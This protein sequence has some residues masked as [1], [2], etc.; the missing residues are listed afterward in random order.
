[1]VK[2]NL[3]FISIT[4]AGNY[5]LFSYG[6]FNHGID[7]EKIDK[8]FNFEKNSH[9]FLN[10]RELSLAKNNNYNSELCYRFWSIKE[11]YWKMNR[12]V[13]FIDPDL[14]TNNH[15]F[16]KSKKS[17]IYN[18]VWNNYSY[19]FCMDAKHP[20]FYKFKFKNVTDDFANSLTF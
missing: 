14:F 18:G 3:Y 2:N 1:M 12:R 15:K 7:I 20:N 17:L 19:A 16:I 10:N 13:F 8:T 4:H 5:C 11:S 6:K 9:L